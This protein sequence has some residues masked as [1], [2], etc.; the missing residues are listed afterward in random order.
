MAMSAVEACGTMSP[1]VKIVA[2]DVDTAVLAKAQAGI[3]TMD[4]VERLSPDR[5][6]RFFL[7]G[8][9]ANEGM[10]RVRPELAALVRFQQVNLLDARYPV[11]GPFDAIF[12]RNVMIYFDRPTQYQILARFAPLLK[13]VACL[14]WS[15][16]TAY[17]MPMQP[18]PCTAGPTCATCS[19]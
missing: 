6:R 5:L 19:R 1:R 8:S 16:L 7:R 13:R 14:A 17:A 9:G 3:Y 15:P 10:V 11:N 4:R 2:S 18:M 12:C